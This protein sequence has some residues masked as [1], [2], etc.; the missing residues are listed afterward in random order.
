MSIII[1]GVDMPKNCMCCPFP[2]VGVDWYYC[3][4]PGVDGKAY[5]FKQ[6]ES[7]PDDCPLVEVP[8]PHGRLID[9]DEITAFSQLE[10]NYEEVES[11][12]EF[13]TVIE[14]EGSNDTRKAKGD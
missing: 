10:I 9:V 14:A 13:P 3:Y 2:H 11:L 1:K 4:C 5:D 12:D 8:E 6:A 7:I